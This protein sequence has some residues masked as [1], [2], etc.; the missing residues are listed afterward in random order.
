[1]A[2]CL[3]SF[4]LKEM[5]ME[6]AISSPYLIPVE[7]AAYLRLEESTLNAMRW[8]KEGPCWRKHGGKVVYHIDELDRWSQGRDS[9]PDTRAGARGQ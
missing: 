9:D 6:H 8:R 1:M 2:A 7:A 5:L 4:D 3:P